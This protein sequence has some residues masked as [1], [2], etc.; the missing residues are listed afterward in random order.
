MSETFSCPCDAPIATPP[1]NLGGLPVIAYRDTDY[2]DIR[3]A[4]LTPQPGETQLTAWRPG[5]DGDLALMMAEWFA[6]LGDIITFYNERIANEDYLGTATQP[7]SVTNLIRLLGYRPQPGIGASVTLAALLQSG[8]NFGQTITIPAGLQ[9]TSKPSPGQTPQTFELNPKTVIAAPDAITATAPL[10]L[11]APSSSTILLAGA[12][13]S[14]LGGDYLFLRPRAGG[15]A[16]LVSVSSASVITPPSGP[17]QTSLNVSFPNNDAP[18]GNTAASLRLD[19]TTLTVSLWSLGGSTNAIDSDGNIHLSGLVRSLKIGD[20]VLFTYPNVVQAREGIYVVEGALP[21][22]CTITAVQDVVWDGTG[23]TPGTPNPS[24]PATS[25]I[26]AHTMLGV[27][28]AL[29]SSTT[30]GISV[31]SF[32]AGTTMFYNFVEA[33]TLVDQPVPVWPGPN[34]SNPPALASASQFP[35]ANGTPVLIA[36]STGAGIAAQA[37]SSGNAN[38]MTVSGMGNTAPSL[39]TPLTVLYNLLPFT[40]GKTVANEVLGS[41]DPTVPNQSFQLAKSPLTYLRPAAALVS[42]LSIAVN[43]QNWTEVP[44]LFNQPAN[45][46]IFVTAQDENQITTVMFGDG[47]NGARLPAGTGN[48]IATYRYG[49]GAA[50]PTAG[51]LTV[52]ATPY[53]G[54][55]AVLNPVGAS[56]GA[57]PDPADQIQSYAPRSVL[58]FGR[59]VSAPD[60]E[61]I[62]AQIAAGT[63]VSALWGWDATNQRGAVTVYVA[64]NGSILTNVQNGLAAVCD[65][66]RPP[67]IVP[68]TPIPVLLFIELLITPGADGPTVEAAVTTALT[69]PMT[70]L[71]GAQKLGIGQSVFN[72]QIS[73]A[74][75]NVPGYAAIEVFY[76]CRYNIFGLEE[77]QLHRVPEGSYFDLDPSNIYYATQVAANG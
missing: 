59:A 2:V 72:S 37:T 61:A 77:Q 70:G 38:S 1:Q 16:N 65:P 24:N 42:T 26:I 53:P 31:G 45:A 43:G 74:C 34:A 54:L 52:I 25:I 46:Q 4:L 12:V 6:Y 28:P 75:Q 73:A 50:T 47:V 8:P 33:A 49:S 40:C 9:V 14:I 36:D 55:R 71:F 63:R 68:A 27:T 22:L 23:S 20:Q 10:V 69:D 57:D 19:K 21:L 51:A 67:K 5:A 11:L 48:V 15:T 17:K 30:T 56:G 60:Y 64:D 66:N 18:T 13:S 58:T 41:G 76:F 44:N 62:A 32:C 35:T 7:R 3:A 29:P 39:Q